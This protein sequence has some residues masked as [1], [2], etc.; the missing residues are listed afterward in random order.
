M[1]EQKLILNLSDNA[2]IVLDN[3]SYHTVREDRPSSFS[4][5]KGITKFWLYTR[6]IRY[7]ED[8]SILEM[9][10]VTK[11]SLRSQLTAF[12]VDMNM[13]YYC[14]TIETRIFILI[15]HV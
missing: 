14:N 3:A 5:D 2:V 4:S 10:Q 7:V 11:M 13:L 15:E 6:E 1:V 9:F 12:W 8:S